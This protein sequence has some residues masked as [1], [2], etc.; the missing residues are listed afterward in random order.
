MPFLRTL[1]WITLSGWAFFRPKIN[2][3]ISMTYRFVRY[4]YP[5]C[6]GTSSI[7]AD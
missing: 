4:A 1:N 6:Q 5:D 2:G 3:K 7:F